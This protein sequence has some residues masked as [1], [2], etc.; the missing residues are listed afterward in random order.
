MT[1]PESSRIVL[2]RDLDHM[3]KLSLRPVTESGGL[4][5]FF[6]E[7]DVPGAEMFFVPRP[8][9]ESNGV[10][11]SSGDVDDVGEIARGPRTDKR[12][13]RDKQRLISRWWR[14]S[15]NPT[16]GWSIRIAYSSRQQAFIHLAS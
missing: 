1:E 8:R 3:R 7:Q 5:V 15:T 12:P 11:L 14:F 16:C 9:D 4:S 10:G 2:D 6:D 13:W